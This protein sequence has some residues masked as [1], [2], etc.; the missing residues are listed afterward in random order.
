MCT[1]AF[2]V[3]VRFPNR[4]LKLNRNLNNN[5]IRSMRN[6]GNMV[7]LIKRVPMS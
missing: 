3:G 5:D 1:C 2:I 6:N 4:N 7:N